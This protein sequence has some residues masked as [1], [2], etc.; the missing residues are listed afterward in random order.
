MKKKILGVFVCML[1]IATVLPVVSSTDKNDGSRMSDE[2]YDDCGC[3][4][5]FPVKINSL[6]SLDPNYVSSKPT[7]MDTPHYFSWKDFGGQDW[8]TSAKHQLIPNPCGSC[9]IFAALGT[10]E[11]IINLRE[12]SAIL[13]PDLSEQYVLSCLPDAAYTPGN[14]CNGGYPY[15]AFRYIEDTSSAG[16]N[17]N[18]IIL[19]SCFPY[20]A[21]DDVP[22]SDKC[23]D[24]A[25]FLIPISDWGYWIPNGRPR[26]RKAIKTQ[27]METGPVA[28]CML[29]NNKIWDWGEVHHDPDDYYPYDFGGS[30]HDVVIVGWKDDP[31]ICH[32]GYWICKNSLGPNWGYE[33]FFNIEYGSLKIDRIY[34]VWVDYDP[35]SFDWPDD[36]NPPDAPSIDGPTTG[37]ASTE[38]EYTFSSTDPNELDVCYYINW[39]DG[40]SEE[41]I[42]PYASDTDIKVNHTW[43][44]QGKY[45]VMAMA[46]N[47][48]DLI[49]PWGT[50]EVTMP[51][52]QQSQ[53]W[54]FLQF[55]QNHPRMFPI[56]GHLLGL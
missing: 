43:I 56:F 29:W 46:M 36:P 33:G 47:T 30:E 35:E 31:S 41:W 52:N 24:W 44:K 13:D 54:W 10:L 37:K 27:I 18:G 21:D 25:D 5:R 38:Y 15:D 17:C 11:S 22:C 1:L 42:G 49:S 14:G 20:Q 6:V 55:L 53:N 32:G 4:T 8:T 40:T 34:I 39:G 7:I 23:P 51:L 19:E 2:S 28:A 26:D 48:N 50:L 45:T 3:G 9:W 16:N 12:G